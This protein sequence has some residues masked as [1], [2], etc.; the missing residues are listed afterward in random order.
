MGT[1]GAFIAVC[2]GALQQGGPAM[3]CTL[4]VVSAFF[5]FALAARLSF[6]RRVFTPIVS[7]TVIMLIAVTVMPIVFDM[8]T[9]VPEGTSTAS[10]AWIALSTIVGNDWRRSQGKWTL[11]IVGSGDWSSSWFGSCSYCR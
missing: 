10:A 8:L 9:D 11:T 4:I 1:S 3:L 7:G 6:F 2:I 5:Q